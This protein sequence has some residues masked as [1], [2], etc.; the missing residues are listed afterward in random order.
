[1]VNILNKEDIDDLRELFTFCDKS[2]SGTIPI[3]EVRGVLKGSK[4]T[5]ESKD[6]KRVIQD[7]D[8]ENKGTVSFPQLLAALQK[9]LREGDPKEELIEAF[10]V[11]DLK[12]TGSVSTEDLI[13]I[14]VKFH[15]E[16]GVSESEVA[17]LV[18]DADFDGDGLIDYNEFVKMLF[19]IE[20]L[21]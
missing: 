10:R 20:Q 7:A 13:D 1:M 17:Q 9:R 16:V 5:L 6:L 11:F 8:E 19:E 2:G 12:N 15:N 4:F 14:I 18:K 3:S 21:E